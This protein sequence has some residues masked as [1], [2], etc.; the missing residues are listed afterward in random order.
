[1]D[2]AL[3]QEL[4]GAIEE[5]GRRRFATT[6][7]LAQ[8]KHTARAT[9]IVFGQQVLPVTVREATSVLA[10]RLDEFESARPALGWEPLLHALQR[11]EREIAGVTGR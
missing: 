6:D 3:L 5:I 9:L 1:V 11:L 8:A 10:N 2:P 4:H 7:A